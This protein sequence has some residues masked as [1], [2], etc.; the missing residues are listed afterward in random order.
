MKYARI[1]AEFYG[2]PWAILPD[3]LAVI[4]AVLHRAAAGVVLTDEEIRAAVG[5]DPAQAQARGAQHAAA[6]GSVAVLPLFGIIAHRAHT[7]DNISGPGGTSTE[8]FSRVFQTALADPNVSA[9]VIDVDSPG[10]NV[11]G[12]S[13]LTDE[14]FAARERKKIVAVAN[15]Q[16]ASGAFWIASAAQELVVTPSGEVGSIGVLAA[17][18]DNSKSLEAQGVKVSLISAGKFKTE[19]NPFEALTDEGHAAIQV[20]VNDYYDMFVKAVARNRGVSVLEVRNGFGEGRMVRAKAAVEA[21]MAD[22][23]AT[24]DETIQRLSAGGRLKNPPTRAS[25]RRRLDLASI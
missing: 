21:G 10:G 5:E 22:R 11:G 20:A 14:I 1:L 3:R 17:H 13:E 9:I 8:R 16:A 25:A 18:Q 24:L 7:V 4:A 6:P 19:G 15:A 12:V 23:V 2:T